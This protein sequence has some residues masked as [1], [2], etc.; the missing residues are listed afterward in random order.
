MAV[1]RPDGREAKAGRRGSE[2]RNGHGE[3][4][5][6]H[7]GREG[8]AEFIEEAAGGQLTERVGAALGEH[9]ARALLVQA[10]E[11]NSEVHGVVTCHEHVG[12]LLGLRD[13]REVG[14]SG[15]DEDGAG[16][17]VPCRGEE[18]DGPV[19]SEGTA[20]HGYPG[21]GLLPS[22]DPQRDLGIGEANRSVALESYGLCAHEDDVG[23]LAQPSEEVLVGWAR[24]G[25]DAAAP[26]GTPVEARHHV[27]YDP[28]AVGEWRPGS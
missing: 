20:H 21:N 10:T 5:A 28:G 4:V 1:I 15:G 19:E 11:G 14:G 8:E 13:R 26:G 9:G 17:S 27:G 25:T 2:G 12:M 22:L 6:A 3:R 7:D 23:Y 18:R 16:V 24:Q